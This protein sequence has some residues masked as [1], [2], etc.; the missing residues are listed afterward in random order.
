MHVTHVITTLVAGGTERMLQRIIASTRASGVEHRVISLTDGGEVADELRH[1]GIPVTSLAMRRA[2]SWPDLMAIGRLASL[3][4]AE[5]PDIVQAWMYHANVLAGIA[6][7][8]AGRGRAV[9]SIRAASLPSGRERARTILLARVAA[10]LAGGLARGVLVNGERARVTHIAA[11]YPSDKMHVIPNGY[12]LSIWH[13]DDDARRA[14]RAELGL[15][16]DAHIVGM[17][18]N[19]RPIKDHPTFLR[20]MRAVRRVMPHTHILLAG[21]GT[22]LDAPEMRRLVESELGSLAGL[23][24]LGSRRDVPRLTAALDVSVLSSIDE[25]FPNVIAEAMASGVPVVSTD[26]GD[27]RTMLGSAEDVV[28]VGD[29][30]ELATRVVWWLRQ[31]RRQREIAGILLRHRIADSYSLGAVAAQYVRYWRALADGATSSR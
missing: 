27:V 6:A 15:G 3:L 30:A 8:L 24:V 22:D 29:S 11:G 23:S 25:S 18:A 31:P 5:P 2:G 13:P 19:F 7:P 14:V 17:I 4:R 21:V 10:A 12:D 28:P 20:A 9:W 16:P 26:V 1:A